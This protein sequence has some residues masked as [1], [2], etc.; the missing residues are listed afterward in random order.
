MEIQLHAKGL[1][2]VTMNTKEEP[3]HVVD[4]DR[5][6]N[7]MDEAFGFLCLSISKDL[8]FHISR[9]KTPK[10]I[11]DQ[12]ASL[13]DKQDDL[14][15][16]QLEN[17]LISLQPGNFKTLNDFFTK[18][19]YLVLQLKKCEV[20]KE[21]DHLILAIVS[22]ICVDYSVFVSTSHSGKLTIPGWK[23]PSLN[24]FIES[25]TNEHDKPIQTGII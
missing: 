12:L 18:F 3:N 24:A 4:K 11:W 14:R 5:L 15:I 10:E 20:K 22:K 16:Y 21:D 23:M 13:Y 25:L 8:L 7:K 19:R 9:L 1:Y 6:F 2:R 17:E